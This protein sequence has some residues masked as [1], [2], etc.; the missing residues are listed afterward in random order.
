MCV[1]KKRARP[2]PPDVPS[3]RL[4]E[5]HSRDGTSPFSSRARGERNW[6]DALEARRVAHYG[7]APTK[8]IATLADAARFIN[9]LG[10]CWLFAP[11][12]RTLE[13]PSLFEAVKGKRNVHIE[14]WDADS[15]RLWAWKSDLPAARRAYYGK[16]LAGKPAFIS[17]KLLPYV[18]TAL[19]AENAA[20]AYAHGALSYDAKKIYDALDGL[21]PQ[22]TVHLRRAAAFDSKDGNPRYHRALD[23]LQRRLIVM[24]MGAT[25]EV[26][27]W[28][29]QIFELVA[30]WFP[31][32][33]A[34]AK[35]LDM[36][37]ARRTLIEG[38]IKTVLAAP[39][40]AP[41][42]LFAIPRDEFK[43]LIG[44]MVKDSRFKVEEG[45]IRTRD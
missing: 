33:A 32:Q 22:P 35:W 25:N 4:V 36:R 40:D 15:D 2:H 45:W 28:T 14:D 30:R 19:G 42:R 23:E 11:S 26:G 8:R 5:R 24:P 44:E 9:R 27:N 16:A 17:L 6:L 31:E 38:Y 20:Q 3:R 21:G 37:T 1:V 39:I 29:S 34:H 43:E 7:I 41:A 12:R 18:I 13:L 10:F